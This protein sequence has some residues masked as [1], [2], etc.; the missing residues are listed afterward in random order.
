MSKY[1]E[2]LCYN[3]ESEYDTNIKG[4]DYPFLEKAKYF[5]DMLENGTYCDY[6]FQDG[7]GFNF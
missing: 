1:Y 3:I 2:D 5:M 4:K 6:V 7:D